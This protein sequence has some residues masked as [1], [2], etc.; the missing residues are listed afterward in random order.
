MLA[1][2]LSRQGVAHKPFY[3]VVVID[4]RKKLGGVALEILG[5]WHPAKDV[6]EINKDKF[7]EWVKKGAK[8]TAAVSKLLGK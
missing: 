2:K 7:K 5:Y 1:I 8:P 6:V 3:R 4:E